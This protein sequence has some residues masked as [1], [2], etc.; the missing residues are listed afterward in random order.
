MMLTF[1]PVAFTASATVLNTGRSRCV[2][3]PLPGVTPP[4]TLVPYSII[5]EA[6]KV[7]SVPVKPCTRTFDCLLT[8]TDIFGG[9]VFEDVKVVKTGDIHGRLVDSPDADALND[10]GAGTQRGAA[11]AAPSGGIG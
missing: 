9:F 11:R 3:P 7:P 8:S 5:C 10:P 1:A 6:W 2:V 4:T